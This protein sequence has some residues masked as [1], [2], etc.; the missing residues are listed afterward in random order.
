MFS[1]YLYDMSE[2]N[3]LLLD[4]VIAP[5]LLYT[6]GHYRRHGRGFEICSQDFQGKM[7][8]N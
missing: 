3:Q 4:E 1:T 7:M 8:I 2:N 6:I 5:S